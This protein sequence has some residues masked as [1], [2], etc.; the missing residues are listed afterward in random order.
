MDRL[1]RS[2]RPGR[3]RASRSRTR[4]G[5]HRAHRTGRGRWPDRGRHVTSKKPSSVRPP[6]RNARVAGV[7][8]G[9][10]QVGRIGIGA[11]DQ[12]RG[13][14]H[15]VG[16]QAR[17]DQLVDCVLRG[18]QHLAAH[19]PALLGGDSWSS[20]CTAAAPASDH[21]LR[22]LE[23]IEVAAE[24]GLGIGDDAAPASRCASSPCMCW[25]WSVRS[26]ALLMR[27]TIFGTES[28]G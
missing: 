26:R 6:V 18:H 17:G 5:R 10:Q 14:A 21:G 22:Q 3:G 16:G 4:A 15:H 8:V 12:H 20:K 2:A 9:L 25:I 24:A 7:E 23:G 27:S 28:T 19:V 13:H 1:R 11:R